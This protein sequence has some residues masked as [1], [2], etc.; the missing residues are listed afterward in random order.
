MN[1]TAPGLEG[2]GGFDAAIE[3]E[4]ARGGPDAVAPLCAWLLAHRAQR[5]CETKALAHV[6][7]GAVPRRALSLCLDRGRGLVDERR[8][9]RT[10]NAPRC[11]SSPATR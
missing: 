4:T 1:A 9:T 5:V 3:K 8:A 6:R 11:R 7:G 2:N 10:Q